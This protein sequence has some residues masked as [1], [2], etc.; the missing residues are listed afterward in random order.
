MK[1]C[2]ALIKYMYLNISKIKIHISRTYSSLASQEA[3]ENEV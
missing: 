2:E 3:I 1:G